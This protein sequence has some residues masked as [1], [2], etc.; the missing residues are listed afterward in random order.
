[1]FN[2]VIRKILF[3]R[4]ISVSLLICCTLAIAV[5]G[6]IPMYSYAVINNSISNE[7]E[8]ML[9]QSGDI[10]MIYQFQSNLE[11]VEEDQIEIYKLYDNEIDKVLSKKVSANIIE[12]Y[13]EVASVKYVAKNEKNNN[14][15]LE[16]SK[17]VYQIP[18]GFS[19]IYIK[20]IENFKQMVEVVEGRMYKENEEYIEVVAASNFLIQPKF[21]VK[22]H[23]H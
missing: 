21:P 1:M 8:N 13:N 22:Y 20:G 16:L 10:G 3:N 14:E 23:L 15:I 12:K 17:D 2:I 11:F 9:E 6:A 5:A 18:S 4:W 7:F 19:D